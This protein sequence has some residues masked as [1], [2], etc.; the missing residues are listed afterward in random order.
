VTTQFSGSCVQNENPSITA[1]SAMQNMA[2]DSGKFFYNPT[3][4]ALTAYFQAVAQSI[5]TPRLVF[6]SGPDGSP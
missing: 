1:F 2:S 4:S 6:I 3:A 5:T